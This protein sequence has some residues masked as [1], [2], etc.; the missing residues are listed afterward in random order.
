MCWDRAALRR[1]LEGREPD[2]V[3]AE[4]TSLKPPTSHKDM[5][6]TNILRIDGTRNLRRPAGS[7]PWARPRPRVVPR[8]LL[9]AMPYARSFVTGGLRVSN[10]RAVSE[11]GWTLE[12]PGYRDGV[13]LL[14]RHYPHADG[15]SVLPERPGCL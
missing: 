1:A 15:V 13:R 6:T 9:A 11:L 14:T 3:I 5:A 8:W 4:F 2:A 7:V 10:A 12:T